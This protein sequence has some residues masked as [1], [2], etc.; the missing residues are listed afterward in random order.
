MNRN[1]AINALMTEGQNWFLPSLSVDCV[2]F[3]FHD[4]QLKV[5]LLKHRH[6]DMWSLPGGFIFKEESS[7]VAAHRVLRERTGLKEI[8]LQQFHAFANTERYNK[9][10]HLNDLEEDGIAVSPDHWILQRFVTIGY[11]AL[12]EFSK[13]IP[14]ADTLTEKCIWWDTGTLPVMMLDHQKIIDTAMLT[15]RS[16]LNYQ[17]IGYELL[18]QK[19]TLPELQKLYETILNK[20]L[21]R[22][23][24]QRKIEG[25]GIV[26]RLPERRK[27]VA[28][29]APFLYSFDSKK[30]FRAL[31]EGLSGGW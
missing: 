24:F 1:E 25:F 23:N 6:R 2:I 8:F 13:V 3:G 4:N 7:D 20:R 12:V 31:T 9:E 10:F 28:H 18:P 26:K 27:D 30:Y 22:R 14:T 11:Y 15:L 16:H 21:D 19:F 17:P 29:K 5:L